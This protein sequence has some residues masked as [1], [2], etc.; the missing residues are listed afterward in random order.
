METDSSRYSLKRPVFG[1][2]AGDALYH[3]SLFDT[4]GMF[5]ED[6]F[7]YLEDVDFNMRAVRAGYRCTYIPDAVVYHVGSATTGSKIN[8]LTVKLT[9]RNSVFVVCKNYSMPIQNCNVR[10]SYAMVLLSP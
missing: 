7:A 10:Y 2:C 3:R 1:A 5:D 9:T 6:F 8:R 4:I